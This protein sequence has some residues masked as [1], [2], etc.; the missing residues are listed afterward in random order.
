MLDTLFTIGQAASALLLLYGAF[1]TLM[2][3]RKVR[4]TDPMLE[5]ESFLLRHLQNDV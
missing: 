3:A 1:L 2:P 4:A 5:E